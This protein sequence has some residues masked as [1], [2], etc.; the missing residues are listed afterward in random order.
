MCYEMAVGKILHNPVECGPAKSGN[1]LT[2]L[3]VE[4]EN[5]QQSLRKIYPQLSEETMI[6]ST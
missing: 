3:K 5:I 1:G 4:S 6:I 2:S